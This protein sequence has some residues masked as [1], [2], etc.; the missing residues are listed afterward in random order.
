[1][2]EFTTMQEVRAQA[3]SKHERLNLERD[4]LI[5]TLERNAGNQRRSARELNVQPSELHRLIHDKHRL[6]IEKFVRIHVPR[7]GG[8]AAHARQAI[9]VPG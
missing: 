4:L 9:A 3:K 1:M 5:E 8:H 6:K 2:E 7:I